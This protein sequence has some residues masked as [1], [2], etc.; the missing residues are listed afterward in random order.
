MRSARDRRGLGL[1]DLD[2]F[3]RSGGA[4]LGDLEQH[5]WAMNDVRI[6]ALSGDEQLGG[7]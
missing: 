1:G 4:T 6:G 3:G 7:R 5:I 2:E